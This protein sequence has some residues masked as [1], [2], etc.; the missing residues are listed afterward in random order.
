MTP[1]LAIANATRP[2]QSVVADAIAHLP[3]RLDAERPA[4]PVTV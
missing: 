1:A 2:D 4:G 3:A